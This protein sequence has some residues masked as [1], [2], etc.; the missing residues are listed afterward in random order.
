MTISGVGFGARESGIRTELR[1]TPRTLATGTTA[2]AGGAATSTVTIP[3]DVAP[4]E[5][6]LL[7]IGAGHT[8]SAPL[9]IVGAGTT[10]TGT[11][12]GSAAEQCFAQGVHGATL[13][14]GVSDRFRSYVTGPIAK[15]SVSTDG[16][17]DGGSA[18]TWSGGKGSFNTDLGK[19]RASFGG[20]VS[21][22]G[23]EGILDLRIS[24]PRVVVDGA[25]GTLVVD[26]RSSDMEGKKS[27]S[28]GVAFASLD[29]SGRSPR[30][31][32]RSRGAAPPRPSR[33]PA[34][35]RSPGSTRPAP[36]WRR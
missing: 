23:H 16:V 14:W 13:S 35:R 9:T 19:G 25:S 3:K 12:S 36:R 4:G 5:H 34:R 11:G 17:R 21:F 30:R 1:S 28:T 2:N 32:P 8:A 6:T 20:S 15:G 31:A 18:F 22:S 10:G 24:N 27:S 26:V 29:L 7:L 33:P